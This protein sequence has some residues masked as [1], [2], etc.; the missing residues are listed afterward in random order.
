[1]SLHTLNPKFKRQSNREYRS[2]EN[3][4]IDEIISLIEAAGSR[5]RYKE[6]DR[7]LLLLMFR[8]GLRASEAATLKWD[9]VMIK[10]KKL[11]VNRLKVV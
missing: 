9:A 8:H 5:G 1:M 2:R 4:E 11:R 7:T 6:R 3:L 10:T